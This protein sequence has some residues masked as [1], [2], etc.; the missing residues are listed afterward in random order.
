MKNN[1]STL[2]KDFKNSKNATVNDNSMLLELNNG[3]E[4][5]YYYSSSE[6]ALYRNNLILIRNIE[7]IHFDTENNNLL[8]INLVLGKNG[9]NLNMPSNPIFIEEN[10]ERSVFM[11]ITKAIAICLILALIHFRRLFGK[12]FKG[13]N[14]INLP[15]IGDLSFN[16][17]QKT[18]QI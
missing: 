4:V 2:I 16:S 7:E 9:K 8:K 13:N 1:Y 15:Q 6:K 10:N 5:S 11:N 18:E 3:L 14:L 12:L 17:D